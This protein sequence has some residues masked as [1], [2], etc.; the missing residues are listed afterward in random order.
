VLIVL[1]GLP[2][3]GKTT[4]ARALAK[5]LGAVHVRIDTIE[6]ALRS[7]GREV[8]PA[9]YVIGYAVTADNLRLGRSVIADSVNPVPATRDAWRAVGERAAVKV[10][11]VELICSDKAAHRDRVETRSTDIEGLQLLT[12]QAVVERDYEPW[13]RP[14]VVLDTARKTVDEAVAELMVSLA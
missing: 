7:A 9:G 12:W 10:V 8:G 11:E 3:T 13:S 6:Q 1:G 14:R 5:R 4:I 2:G